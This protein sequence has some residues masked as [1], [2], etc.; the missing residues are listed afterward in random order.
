MS[1]SMLS[2]HVPSALAAGALEVQTDGMVYRVFGAFAGLYL[3]LALGG[4]LVEKVGVIR[5]GCSATCWCKGPVLK[6]F[7]WVF[8]WG[9]R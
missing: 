7:R 5:C 8:P 2:V 3:L 1:C 6:P 9:H 4:R